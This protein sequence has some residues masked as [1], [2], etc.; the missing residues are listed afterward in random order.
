MSETKAAFRL[1]D[2]VIKESHII[3]NE[4]GEYSLDINLSPKG[5]ILK[6]LNQFILNLAVVVKDTQDRFIVNIVTQAT[7]E[8]DEGADVESYKS[9]YFT[10]N[11][12]AIVFPYIRSYISSLTAQSGLLTI[13]LPTLNLSG[14]AGSLKENIEEVE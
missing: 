1:V 14:L 2:F 4:K 3:F 7:F 11:A 10:T 13:T 8:F 9:S 5:S 12:P 6:S